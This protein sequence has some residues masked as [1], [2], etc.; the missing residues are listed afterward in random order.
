MER[1]SEI[2]N[3]RLEPSAAEESRYEGDKK[4]PPRATLFWNLA[5]EKLVAPDGPDGPRQYL[6]CDICGELMQVSLD[7]VAGMCKL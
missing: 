7:C 4:G 2:Q 3:A 1:S 6:P 5:T